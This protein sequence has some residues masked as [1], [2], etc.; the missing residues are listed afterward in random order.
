M[1]FTRTK[2][3]VT[4]RRIAKVVVIA[5]LKAVDQ[6]FLYLFIV[7]LDNLLKTSKTFTFADVLVVPCAR[8][9]S[10]FNILPSQRETPSNHRRMT[11]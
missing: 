11:R 9:T 10:N 6:E 5:I 3:K 8:K 1:Q 4:I 2:S 7:Y